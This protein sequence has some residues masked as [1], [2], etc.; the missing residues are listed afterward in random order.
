MD[1]DLV[2]TWTIT[3][4]ITLL[5]TDFTSRLAIKVFAVSDVKPTWFYAGFFYQYVDILPVGLSRINKRI[6]ATINDP[7]IF[8]PQ[9]LQLPYQ[10]NFQK[11]DWIDSLKLT[12]YEDPMPLNFDP[13]M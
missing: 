9:N 3:D 1:W 13:V 8:I 4:F 5:P 2:G 11:A 10:L 6:Y 7:I 12:I